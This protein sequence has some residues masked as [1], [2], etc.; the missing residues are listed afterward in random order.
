MSLIT[1]DLQQ[2]WLVVRE[3][4]DSIVSAKLRL[5]EGELK[6]LRND[7]KEAYDMIANHEQ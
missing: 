6:A 4:V 3:E 5:F 1:D 7:I 2:I